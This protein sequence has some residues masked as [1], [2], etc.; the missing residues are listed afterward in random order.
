MSFTAKPE[1]AGEFLSMDSLCVFDGA[2][3]IDY[4]LNYLWHFIVSN[5]GAIK[6]HF[7]LDSVIPSVKG[8]YKWLA[9]CSKFV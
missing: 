4:L 3:A 6:M 7:F 5:E 2:V 8:G 1:N 9:R